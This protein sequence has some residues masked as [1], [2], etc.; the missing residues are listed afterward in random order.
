MEVTEVQVDGTKGS[1]QAH[2]E[3]KS[4]KEAAY[5]LGALLINLKILE[6]TLSLST[7]RVH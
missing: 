3:R 7:K 1:F 4:M 2:K 5:L 6:P